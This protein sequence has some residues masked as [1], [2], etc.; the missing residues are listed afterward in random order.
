MQVLFSF[1][2]QF[3][4]SLGVLADLESE[5]GLLLIYSGILEIINYF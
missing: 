4:V 2:K 3:K 1:F 5:G